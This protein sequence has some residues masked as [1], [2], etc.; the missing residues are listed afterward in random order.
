M[1]LVVCR[2]IDETAGTNFGSAGN[3]G[4]HAVG[5]HVAESGRLNR[6]LPGRADA[7][8]DR[9]DG[10]IGERRRSDVRFGIQGCVCLRVDARENDRIVDVRPDVVLDDVAHQIR[11]DRHRAGAGHAHHDRKDV[12]FG[13]ER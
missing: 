1:R 6:D 3:R 9:H 8:S 7:R 5:D 10:G 13:L 2:Q 11:A 12:G 4:V